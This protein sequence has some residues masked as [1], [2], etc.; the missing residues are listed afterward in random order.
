[1]SRSVTQEFTCSCE[2]RFSAP[3]Y[4][5]ANVTL[6]P[7]LKDQIIRGEFNVVECPTC[8]RRHD[9]G[10]PFLYHDMEQSLSIWVYP[11]E[12]A[13]R[14]DEI[15]AK[16]RRARMVVAS[17]L[18]AEMAE[19]EHFGLDLVFGVDRLIQRLAM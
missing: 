18:P 13:A 8:H 16:L 6:H 9:A 10:V 5:S 4:K 12:E 15:R 3:V 1:M 17:A 11:S 19:N 14:E 2:R 7:W